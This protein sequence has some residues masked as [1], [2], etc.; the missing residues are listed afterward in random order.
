MSEI[1]SNGSEGCLTFDGCFQHS[2]ATDKTTVISWI[3]DLLD[4]SVV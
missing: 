2:E 3:L 1:M 4:L